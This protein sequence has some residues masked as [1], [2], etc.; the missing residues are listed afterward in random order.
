MSVLRG[1]WLAPVRERLGKLFDSLDAQK[2]QPGRLIVTLLLTLLYHLVRIAQVIAGSWALGLEI[3]II[4]F[5]IIVPAIHLAVLLP[6]SVGGIGVR[7][8][9]FVYLFGLVGVSNEAAFTLAV[10]VLVSR[11]SAIGT[12]V[13][14][15]ALGG[16]WRPH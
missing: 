16:L 4:H 13:T 6:I 8:A 14:L 15:Y 10:L 1:S 2:R 9:G 5:V 7:E 12:G 11:L 3:D